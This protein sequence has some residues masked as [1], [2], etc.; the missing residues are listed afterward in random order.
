M[1]RTASC[2]VALC[3]AEQCV[4]FSAEQQVAHTYPSSTTSWLAVGAQGLAVPAH[5]PSCSA[6][7]RLLVRE[8]LVQLPLSLTSPRTRCFAPQQTRAVL[9]L[10][11]FNLCHPVHHPALAVEP[12]VAG[13]RVHSSFIFNMPLWEGG[14][15]LLE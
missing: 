11:L 4:G 14:L 9:E 6:Q 10:A 13:D 1:T 8:E 5:L 2:L 7:K 3:S 15:S 12:K